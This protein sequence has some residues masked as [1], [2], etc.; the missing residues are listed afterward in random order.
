MGGRKVLFS[1]V[2]PGSCCS[3]FSG[4]CPEW[5]DGNSGFFKQAK[6]VTICLS[7]VVAAFHRKQVSGLETISE[8][9]PL[10]TSVE[11]DWTTLESRKNPEV[12]F[13]MSS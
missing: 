7:R 13:T 2:T 3:V 1:G 10:G 9:Y 8:M 4:K 11:R 5:G 6:E 12:F